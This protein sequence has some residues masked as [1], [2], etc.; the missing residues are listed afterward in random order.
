MRT[1]QDP[2]E[3]SIPSAKDEVPMGSGKGG[4][5]G[6]WAGISHDGWRTQTRIPREIGALGDSICHLHCP[7]GLWPRPAK[8]PPQSHVHS[9]RPLPSHQTSNHR[10]HHHD[11]PSPTGHRCPLQDLS[12]PLFLMPGTPAPAPPLLASMWPAHRPRTWLPSSS[13]PRPQNIRRGR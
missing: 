12:T 5:V 11:Q 8:W 9:P 4:T 7:S 6:S 10:S 2:E 1:F 3:H 13:P